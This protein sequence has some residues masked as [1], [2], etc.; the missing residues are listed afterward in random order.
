MTAT[1]TAKVPLGAS[2]LNRKW[3]LDVNTGSDVTPVWTGVFGISDFQP[4]VNTTMQTDSDYDSEG[5]MSSTATAIAWA[6]NITLQRKSTTADAAEYDPGQ[7]ALR[8]VADEL[9]LDNRVHVRWYEMNGADGPQVE[10]YEGHA[11]VSWSPNGGGMDALSTVAVVL[12][13]QGKRT[14]ITHPATP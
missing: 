14:A 9:G 6:L 11:S 13:G 1:D 8:L 7:E 5:Y 12:Q 2:T 3:Y 10:A 4:S